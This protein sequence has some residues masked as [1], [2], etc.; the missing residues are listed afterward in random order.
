MPRLSMLVRGR[1]GCAAAGHLH[2]QG[3]RNL[4]NNAAE[5]L[6]M[7]TD[8]FIQCRNVR[9]LAASHKKTCRQRLGSA[10]CA[11]T[12]SPRGYSALRLRTNGI[13]GSSSNM[14]RMP[15]LPKK[16]LASVRL[17]VAMAVG[18]CDQ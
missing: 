5:M 3:L 16:A 9:S 8:M 10:S 17:S 11:M 12:S 13:D 4:P 15:A 6:P 1:L 18:C 7:V 14:H 2:R